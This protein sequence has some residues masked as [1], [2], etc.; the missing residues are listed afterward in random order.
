MN[1]PQWRLQILA[2]VKV[3][4]REHGFRG[5]H[6]RFWKIIGTRRLLVQLH[7]G[8]DQHDTQKLLMQVFLG[9]D[10]LELEEPDRTRAAYFGL[11]N[12]QLTWTNSVGTRESA[13]R[14]YS[15]AE[16]LAVQE[17]IIKALPPA[18][19]RIEERFQTWHDVLPYMDRGV[20]QTLDPPG[21]VKEWKLPKVL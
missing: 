15:E 5:S 9:I 12:G 11:W 1:A 14:A 13:W 21:Q 6:T 19:A 10:F 20:G 4:L 8:S 17:G 2:G 7:G 3:L 16:A 18:L